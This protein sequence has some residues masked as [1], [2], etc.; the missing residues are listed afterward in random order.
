MRS[1]SE[2]TVFEHV[3]YDCGSNDPV[4]LSIIELQQEIIIAVTLVQPHSETTSLLEVW[5][6]S[7]TE[8]PT[9]RNRPYF[10]YL[11]NTDGMLINMGTI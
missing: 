3:C 11:R 8:A 5:S 7:S 9:V 2:P 1:A 6:F 10:N 4:L